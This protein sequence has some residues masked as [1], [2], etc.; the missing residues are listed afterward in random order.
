MTKILV[1]IFK[2]PMSNSKLVHLKGVKSIKPLRDSLETTN[3]V[4]QRNNNYVS[5]NLRILKSASNNRN[6]NKILKLAHN[7]SVH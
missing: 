3:V 4:L 5:M 7:Y 1:F 2:I 6:F